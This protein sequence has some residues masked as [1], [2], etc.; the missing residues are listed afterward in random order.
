MIMKPVHFIQVYLLLV[1]GFGGEGAPKIHFHCFLSE[2]RPGMSVVFP[3]SGILGLSFDS[4][5][6]SPL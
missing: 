5:L 1:S 4:T 2:G 3:L 6:L